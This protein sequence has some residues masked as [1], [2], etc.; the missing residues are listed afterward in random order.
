ML[1]AAAA[2]FS[3][4][5]GKIELLM[6]LTALE[7]LWLDPRPHPTIIRP[8]LSAQIG[9]FSKLKDLVLCLEWEPDAVAWSCCRSLTQLTSLEKL[10]IRYTYPAARWHHIPSQLVHLDCYNLDDEAVNNMSHLVQLKDLVLDAPVVTGTALKAVGTCMSQLQELTIVWP[11]V[12]PAIC[13]DQLQAL[14][15]MTALQ[16]LKLT[17]LPSLTVQDV[18]SIIAQASSVTSL[19][20]YACSV[21]DKT[22]DLSGFLV[23]KHMQNLVVNIR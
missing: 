19:K 4:G 23:L 12:E 6:I 17:G 10:K 16:Q 9:R 5:Y 7:V 13:K 22:L 21:V 15:V 1:L 2:A 20:L 3:G 18:A 14:Q 8:A 11:K